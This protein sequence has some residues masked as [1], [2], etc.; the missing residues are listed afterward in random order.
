MVAGEE[1][2]R[3]EDV[4]RNDL[5]FSI[6]RNWF[7]KLKSNHTKRACEHRSMT[8]HVKPPPP[9]PKTIPI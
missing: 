1:A 5:G 6:F 2:S 8:N 4:G 9:T 3:W 7:L